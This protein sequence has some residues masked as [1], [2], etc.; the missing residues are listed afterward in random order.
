MHDQTLTCITTV[1]LVSKSETFPSPVLPASPFSSPSPSPPFPSLRPKKD[2]DCNEGGLERGNELRDSRESAGESERER[3]RET[4][5]P[6]YG[7]TTIIYFRSSSGPLLLLSPFSP[8]GSGGCGG[9][10]SS[11]PCRLQSAGC[12]PAFRRLRPKRTEV[13]ELGTEQQFLF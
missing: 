4:N 13:D 8:L 7:S 1:T 5:G 10:A 6:C 9:G 2:L 12:E 11:F 3:E